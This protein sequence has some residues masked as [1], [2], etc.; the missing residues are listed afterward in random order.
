ML[1]LTALSSPLLRGCCCCCVV[2]ALCFVMCSSS[3][4][5]S[6]LLLLLLYGT[7]KRANVTYRGFY[8]VST[9]SEH[10]VWEVW[11]TLYSRRVRVERSHE[12][13]MEQFIFSVTFPSKTQN[14]SRPAK[15]RIFDRNTLWRC[16]PR[17]LV[18]TMTPSFFVVFC[19]H[20]EQLHTV[21]TCCWRYPQ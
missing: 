8:S 3:S 13:F 11:C 6:I 18:W 12:S 19:A 10:N 4:G 2:A 14:A 7:T 21:H 17:N 15:R 1:R 16:R 20:K 5:A 9:K